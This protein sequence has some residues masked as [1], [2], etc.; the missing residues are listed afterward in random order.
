MDKNFWITAWEEGRTGFHQKNFHPKLVQYFPKLSFLKGQRV[1]VPLCGKTHDMFWLLQQGLQVQGVEL[2]EPAVAEFFQENN[3]PRPLIDEESDFKHYSLHDITIIV[4]DFF[5]LPENNPYD[6]IYDRAALVALPESMRKD[7]AEKI[8]RLIKPQG[9]MLLITYDYIPEEMMA[10]PFSVP[11]TEIQK[12]YAK[13]FSIKL[14]ESEK[15]KEGT[16]L[17]AVP[18]LTQNVYLLERNA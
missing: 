10:P 3:L 8:S 18:S 4:G 5:A 14:L 9:K 1:L 12:L 7:Y 15:P 11:E 16:R 6:L 13:N 2:F 17:D